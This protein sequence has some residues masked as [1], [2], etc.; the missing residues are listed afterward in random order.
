MYTSVKH[1]QILI[2]L[3]KQHDISHIVINPGFT[4]VPIVQGIQNDPHFTCYSIVDERSA[5]YF[6][7]GLHLKTGERIATTCTSAQATRNYIPGLTEA[8]YKKVPI[9]AITVSKH[10]KYDYQ[11][12]PQHPIQTSLPEDAV[13]K[14]FAL[15]YVSD[16]NAELQCVR[17][18]NEAILELTHRCMGPV[19]VNLPL[20]D[21][22]LMEFTTLE[23]PKV[24]VI[25][26]YMQWDVWDIN[27]INKKI[28]LVIGECRPMT[29]KQKNALER[30][31]ESQNAFVYVNHLSNYQGKYSV[32]A[33]ILLATISEEQFKSDFQPDI[34]F[35]IGGQ[36][37][38]YALL[39]KLIPGSENEFEHY[40]ISEDGE[41]VDTFDKLTKVFEVPFELFFAKLSLNQK[42]SH[43]YYEYWVTA[44]NSIQIPDTLPLSNIY[45]AQQLHEQIPQNSTLNFAILNSL[46]SWSLFELHP[47]ITCYSNVAAFG[48]DG[49][50]STFLGQSIITDELCF[51]V[52]GDLAFGYDMNSLGI[53]HLKNNIRILL[54]NNGCGVEFRMS[55]QLNNELGDE[56]FPYIAAKGHS[57]M[58]KAWAESCGFKYISAKT[59]EELLTHQ[60]TL[61][62]ESDRPIL[63]ELFVDPNDELEA[64]NMVMKSN[65]IES[66][67]KAAA[68]AVLGQKGVN[69]LKR[70]VKR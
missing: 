14:T 6:A 48:I 51:M 19:Q 62:S 37:G 16:I 59:K 8:F 39:R 17:M 68:R 7:I 3:L 9:L 61:V 25:N 44:Y 31:V 30:F 27:L 43:S 10:P 54:V 69:L 36:S 65:I 40:H 23:L 52:I 13:K 15:P 4:N 41:I 50:L 66:K 60:N 45:L 24:R 47:S 28:M 29:N 49:G 22:D 1:V 12:Y 2:S 34:L 63:F 55:K 38:D 33:N 5:M 67:S 35:T 20:L 53:R 46:R 57:H 26:R 21:S 56:I 42:D 70:I 58:A 11:G 64:Y 32:A 18:V